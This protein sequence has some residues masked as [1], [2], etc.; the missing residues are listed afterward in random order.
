M[1]ELTHEQVVDYLSNLPVIQLCDLVKELETKWGVSSAP[2]VQALPTVPNPV[3]EE[4]EQT[5]FDVSLIDAGPT[6]VQVIKAVRELTSLG[7]KEAKE[8]VDSAPVMIKEA[9][10]KEEAA[11]LK[12][13]LEA[14]GA[15]VKVK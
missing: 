12:E 5:Q 11:A 14:A 6:R 4:E 7:L 1:S 9:V 8:L 10:S 15:T 2:V 3:V 13:R